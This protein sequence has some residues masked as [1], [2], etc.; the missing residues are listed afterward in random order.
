MPQGMTPPGGGGSLRINLPPGGAYTVVAQNGN[1]PCSGTINLSDA[2]G[3]AYFPIR[4]EQP[5]KD[6]AVVRVQPETSFPSCIG[7]S[8]QQTYSGQSV[9]ANISLYNGLPVLEWNDNGLEYIAGYAVPLAAN[10]YAANNARDVVNSMFQDDI[11]KPDG[12]QHWFDQGSAVPYLPADYS[13][14]QLVAKAGPA[15]PPLVQTLL[16]L[17]PA[18]GPVRAPSVPMRR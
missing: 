8:D 9:T 13:G 2:A 3:N 1:G 5:S 7:M 10:P 12:L 11:R 16:N 14:N 17:C 18:S 4:Y 6:P 15:T